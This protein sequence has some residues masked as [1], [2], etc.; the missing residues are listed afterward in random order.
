MFDFND[1][2]LTNESITAILPAAGVHD[3]RELI[4]FT[5]F[6][7]P[8]NQLLEIQL[9]EIHSNLIDTW[10]IFDSKGR[11]ATQALYLSDRPLNITSLAPGAYNLLLIG[12]KKVIAAKTFVKG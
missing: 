5:V 9:D 12:N 4:D 1:A 6:P 3:Q 2:I 10:I 7:N 11:I 8:A